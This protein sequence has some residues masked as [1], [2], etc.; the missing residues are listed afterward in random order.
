MPSIRPRID[1]SDTP[2]ET[3]EAEDRVM[4]AYRRLLP[5]LRS[6]RLHQVRAGVFPS[7]TSTDV[8]LILAELANRIDGMTRRPLLYKQ[9]II[10][11]AATVLALLEAV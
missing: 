11:L 7:P 10:D 1:L 8:P 5:A 6:A 3:I 4:S 2:E 9:D